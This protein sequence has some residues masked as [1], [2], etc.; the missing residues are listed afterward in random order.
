MLQPELTFR[1]RVKFACLLQCI[2]TGMDEGEMIEAF[3]SAIDRLKRDGVKTAALGWVS[4]SAKA[5]GY[6]A[7]LGLPAVGL[8]SAALGKLL[9]QTAKNVQIG[10]IP[11]T[12][13]LKLLD[14]IAAYHRTA[15]EINRRTQENEEQNKQK[16]KPS[17]RRMF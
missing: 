15:D 13:E 17:V 7:A 14:E 12:D 8:G 10:R 11:T 16:S 9:G 2:E 4:P 6:M 1:D 3:R 5:L